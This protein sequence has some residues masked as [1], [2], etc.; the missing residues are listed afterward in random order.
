MSIHPANWQRIEKAPSHPLV[1][2]EEPNL[3]RDVFPYDEVPRTVFD[4]VT[5]D[6]RPAP[7]I[8]MTDTT[9]RDGQ[10]A[11]TPFTAEQ[12]STLFDLIHRLSGPNGIIRQ[13]EFFIYSERDREVL[14]EVRNKG[15]RFPEVTA[16]IRANPSDFEL[17]RQAGLK[18]TG[19]LT[20]ISDYHIFL[21]FKKTRRQVLDDFMKVVRAAAEA[22]L[23]AIR[24][25]YEDVT[26]AD[27]WGCVVPFTEELMEFSAH[28]GLRIKIRLCD[29]MGYG[30]PYA[31]AALPRSVPK[32]IYYLQREFGIPS[33]N[34]E[35]HGHNDFHKVHING[36]AAW[37]SGV[38]AVNGTIL[39][40]GERTGNS[41]LEALAVEYASLTGSTNGMDLSA[42]TDIANYMRSIGTV[43]APNYPFA[44]ENFNVT[45]A[46]IH[47]D[48]V[49]KNEEIYNIF[50]TGKI[51]NRPL[52]V[53]ITDRSGIAGVGYWV[54]QQL[55]KQGK[56]PVDKRDARVA[57]I[58][59][60]IEAQYANGR[61]TA[62]SQDEMQ[63]QFAL[64][65]KQDA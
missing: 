16:W 60:W 28:S 55:Q 1:D 52:G 25:H 24:C 42:I 58:F 64:H 26:R 21:K 65:F 46:G 6:A 34:L 50:D 18:E 2:V 29:T 39:G 62:I 30:L 63:Q 5:V 15:Y 9:F 47:A 57:K 35:W 4:G 27:F 48:G 22:G 12:A 3:M 53:H 31:T 43:I 32:M 17:V 11:R 41:P 56:P 61:V 45:M 40:F 38:A 37:L 51:L 49:I 10:Q 54:S 7:E 23:E 33:A 13:S 14:E 59:E 19:L 36:V 44:G 20:S 8:W